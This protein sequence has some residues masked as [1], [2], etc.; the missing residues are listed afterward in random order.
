MK[1]LFKSA[2][3]A[4]AVFAA[5][6]AMAQTHKDTTLGQKIGHTAKKGWSATK[7]AGKAVGN[8]TA[9]L[10]SKGASAVADKKYDDKVGPQGQTIYID[11]DSKYYYVNKKGHHVYVSKARLKNKPAEMK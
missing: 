6:S 1:K 4:A 11:K 2:L 7:K 3:F 5:S 9:E 8:K 10:A